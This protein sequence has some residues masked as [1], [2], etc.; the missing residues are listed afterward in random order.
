ML[1]P[2]GALELKKREWKGETRVSSGTAGP[3]TG[4]AEGTFQQAVSHLL[5]EAADL[6]VIT[7]MS[8]G[9]PEAP[10]DPGMQKEVMKL[11]RL[12]IY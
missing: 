7:V 2:R 10:L 9:R 8:K 3:T 12:R 11:C 1:A 6:K 4:H 5:K